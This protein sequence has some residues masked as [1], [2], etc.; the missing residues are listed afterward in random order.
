[1]WHGWVGPFSAPRTMED[2]LG[3]EGDSNLRS[4]LGQQVMG[5]TNVSKHGRDLV[6]ATVG[7]M[8]RAGL[9]EVSFW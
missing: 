8:T 1:M 7:E 2:G 5:A 6:R 4:S 3:R 9:Q